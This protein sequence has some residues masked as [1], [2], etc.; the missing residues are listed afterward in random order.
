[1]TQETFKIVKEKFEDNRSGEALYIN[2]EKLREEN[3]YI[4]LWYACDRNEATCITTEFYY[5]GTISGSGGTP[6]KPAQFRE[7]LKEN[8]F[9]Q[10]KKFTLPPEY[11][12]IWVAMRTD[13]LHYC[14]LK[15]YDIQQEQTY[16]KYKVIREKGTTFDVLGQGMIK[17]GIAYFFKLGIED[18]TGKIDFNDTIMYV[19]FMKD[20]P[21][22]DWNLDYSSLGIQKLPVLSTTFRFPSH[23]KYSNWCGQNPLDGI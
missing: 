2:M 11:D 1:M 23:K 16:I 13:G 19:V 3:D 10:I 17:G 21:P 18:M 14:R 12:H 8:S 15:V 5:A 6:E 7:E 20:C 4:G 22:N 9:K